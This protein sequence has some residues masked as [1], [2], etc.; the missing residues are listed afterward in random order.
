MPLTSG[1]AQMHPATMSEDIRHVD[2]IFVNIH[3]LGSV[4]TEDGE[5]VAVGIPIGNDGEREAELT[6]AYK[7]LDGEPLF[8]KGQGYLVMQRQLITRLITVR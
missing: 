8:F 5:G 1:D 3:G 6:G 7:G 4:F 2:K